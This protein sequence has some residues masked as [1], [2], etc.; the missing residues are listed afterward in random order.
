MSESKSRKYSFRISAV[1]AVFSI[2]MLF[3]TGNVQA[4][5][6]W[7]AL[8]SGSKVELPNGSNTELTGRI[9]LLGCGNERLDTK[10]SKRR[11]PFHAVKFYNTPEV[12]AAHV[13]DPKSAEIPLFGGPGVG[14]QHRPLM[15]TEHEGKVTD[16]TWFLQHKLEQDYGTEALIFNRLL[17]LD[18]NQDSRISF[19]DETQICPDTISLSLVIKDTKDTYKAVLKTSPSG[20]QITTASPKGDRKEEIVG[21][22]TII[23]TAIPGSEE[24]IKSR[25]L[26]SPVHVDQSE[27]SL[28]TPQDDATNATQT[29]PAS[30]KDNRIRP[31]K[32]LKVQP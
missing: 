17:A 28:S 16:F 9:A 8:E 24:I 32:L 14:V 7:Y 29:Q 21:R 11:Y 15:T 20:E 5:A 26:E 13:Y 27:K 25:F 31:K 23:A 6:L 19:R 30:I 2:S 4:D 12:L 10:S 18:E 22:V 3:L 1:S